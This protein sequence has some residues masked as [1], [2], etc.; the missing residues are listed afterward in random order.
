M[1]KEKG[2]KMVEGEEEETKE[3]EKKME[4][5]ETEEEDMEEEEGNMLDKKNLQSI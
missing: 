3:E 4:E 2:I 5:E 1:S